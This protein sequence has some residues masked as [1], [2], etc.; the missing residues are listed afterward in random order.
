[1]I[2]KEEIERR[3]RVAKYPR[4]AAADPRSAPDHNPLVLED[5][6]KCSGSG[7]TC[8]GGPGFAVLLECPDC[9][10]E[11]TTYALV[12]RFE[13]DNPPVAVRI[14]D[15]GWVTCA[16]CGRRFALTDKDRWTGLRHVSCG[17]RLVLEPVE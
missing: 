9:H 1:L 8:E 15:D 2:K 12:P 13:N 4:R 7:T 16:H 11:G 5:C 6:P 17:Q 10:G 3:L 14:E